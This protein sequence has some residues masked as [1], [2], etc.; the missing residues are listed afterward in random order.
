[1][2]RLDPGRPAL[3][4]VLRT[5]GLTT[6]R[7][8]DADRLLVNDGPD[9]VVLDLARDRAIRLHDRPQVFVF[10]AALLAVGQGVVERLERDSLAVS[11]HVDFAL[12]EGDEDASAPGWST[13][14]R[15]FAEGTRAIVGRR[16]FALD[17]QR[18]L[19]ELGALGMLSQDERRVLA[20]GAVSGQPET[21]RTHIVDTHSGA[22]VA[23]FEDNGQGGPLPALDATG[24]FA[25][26]SDYDVDEQLRVRVFVGDA[27][28]G[29]VEV[30]RAHQ[31]TWSTSY[32]QQLYFKGPKLCIAMG[33]KTW[34]A[35]G[36]PFNVD[37]RGHL[38]A[39]FDDRYHHEASDFWSMKPPPPRRVLSI[40]GDYRL[41]LDAATLLARDEELVLTPTAA[42]LAA[43][44]ELR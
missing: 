13:E 36:C 40:Y 43:A 15:L 3:R 7:F 9:T 28:T 2:Y 4:W 42:E 33:G 1:M 11:A 27:T 41:D 34:S 39:S 12:P 20:L 37:T 44:R 22:I 23:S 30:A 24:R 26:W 6:P 17:E 19:S 25:A 35:W 32:A 38:S 14:P 29:R 21:Q 10:D 18:L 31:F 16:L 8:L 5:E